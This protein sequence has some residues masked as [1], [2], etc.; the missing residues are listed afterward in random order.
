MI[1]LL[2]NHPAYGQ[3]R[4]PRGVRTAK[5]IPT[6][7]SPVKKLAAPAID[8]LPENAFIKKGTPP[9]ETLRPKT[10]PVNVKSTKR[11]LVQRIFGHPYVLA[12]FQADVKP[13]MLSSLSS[14]L[15]SRQLHHRVRNTFR[16]AVSAQLAHSRAA[17]M[18]EVGPSW[19][20]APPLSSFPQDLYPGKDFIE[21]PQQLTDYFLSEHNR[22]LSSVFP[23]REQWRRRVVSNISN[24]HRAK[25]EVPPTQQPDMARLVQQFPRQTNYL[26]LS[27]AHDVPQMPQQ[28]TALLKEMRVRYPKRPIFLFTEFLPA[29]ETWPMDTENVLLPK[30]IPIWQTAQ[31][32]NIPVNMFHIKVII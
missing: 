27:E 6:K 3:K 4:L 16:Q 29:A 23:Q 14:A 22:N 18:V 12:N 31:K 17:A 7:Q 15:V 11:T 25:K 10:P 32:E 24:F 21:T 2:C 19:F 26:L 9:S 5:Q 30:Y 20:A 28:I 13:K 1:L 8:I